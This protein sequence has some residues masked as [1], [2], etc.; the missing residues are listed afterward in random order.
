MAL[1]SSER[2]STAIERFAP[3]HVV[4]E[5]GYALVTGGKAA[6]DVPVRGL[7]LDDVRPQLCQE[8]P[9]VRARDDLSQLE[10]SNPL[11]RSQ[12]LLAPGLPQ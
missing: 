1:P 11:E 9:S 7:H 6:R 3:V 10:H 2:R 5:R 4:K 8:H 12:G